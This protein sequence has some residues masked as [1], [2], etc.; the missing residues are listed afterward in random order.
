MVKGKTEEGET[1]S[2]HIVDCVVVLRLC[3]ELFCVFHYGYVMGSMN[4][5]IG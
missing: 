2:Q 4:V 3:F 1:D 5:D